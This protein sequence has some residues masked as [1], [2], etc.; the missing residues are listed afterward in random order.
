[1][2]KNKQTDVV[3]NTCILSLMYQ[4]LYGSKLL[5][6]ITIIKFRVY[7]IFTR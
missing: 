2:D 7:G 6:F 1:M 4:M 3:D 5:R